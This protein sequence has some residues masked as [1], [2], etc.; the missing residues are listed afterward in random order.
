MSISKIQK[1]FQSGETL[2]SEDLNSII[3]TVNSAIDKLNDVESGLDN[4]RYDVTIPI[5]NIYCRTKK[6]VNASGYFPQT[7]SKRIEL[8]NAVS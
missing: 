6:S 3:A 4:H 8:F 2:A 7:E 5:T 1:T